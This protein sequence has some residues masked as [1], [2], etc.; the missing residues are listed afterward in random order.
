LLLNKSKRNVIKGKIV[1]KWF[2]NES[3]IDL[4]AEVKNEAPIITNRIKIVKRY[5]NLIEDS[6]L[7]IKDIKN[8]LIVQ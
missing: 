3:K 5:S 4:I 1:R 7:A 6:E 8:K 2:I